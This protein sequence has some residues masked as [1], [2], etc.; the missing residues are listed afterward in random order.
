M[1][2]TTAITALFATMALAAPAP[3]PAETKSM[4]ADASWTIE[5]MK[6]TCTSDLKSCTWDFSINTHSGA[7]QACSGTVAGSPATQTDITTAVKCGNFQFTAGWSNQFGP[8]FTTL[9][10]VDNV[11]RLIAYP[12]YTDAQLVNATVVTPDQSYTPQAL[13]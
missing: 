1:Q 5:S 3:A 7:A 8:G 9:A 12:A 13:S 6:R 10:V 11:N 2:F 4:M